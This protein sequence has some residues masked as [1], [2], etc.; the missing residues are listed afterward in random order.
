ME[1]V[2]WYIHSK[3]HGLLGEVCGFENP[4]QMVSVTLRGRIELNLTKKG[5]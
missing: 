3:Y 2:I 1:S 5:V 4:Q